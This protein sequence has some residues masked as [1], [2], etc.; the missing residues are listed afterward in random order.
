MYLAGIK[1]NAIITA[2]LSADLAV[3]QSANQADVLGTLS[4]QTMDGSVRLSGALTKLCGNT[5]TKRSVKTRNSRIDRMT[6]THYYTQHVNKHTSLHNTANRF[7]FK[8]EARCF[9]PLEYYYYS[10]IVYS[11]DVVFF[12]GRRQTGETRHCCWVCRKRLFCSVT[13]IEDITQTQK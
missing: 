1:S 2:S 3:F 8:I 13:F 4:Y 6:E 9:F 7:V 11:W 10:F 12:Y 5:K